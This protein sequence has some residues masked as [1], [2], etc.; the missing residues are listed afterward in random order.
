MLNLHVF[1]D[2]SE[3][4]H[5]AFEAE[6]IKVLENAHQVLGS[7]QGLGIGWTIRVDWLMLVHG[8]KHGWLIDV[9]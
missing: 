5:Q 3:S 1:V 8:C 9:A 2:I 7:L 4:R 6:E